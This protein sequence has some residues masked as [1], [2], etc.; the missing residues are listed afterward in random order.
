MGLPVPIYTIIALQFL[1]LLPVIAAVSTYFFHRTG[2]IWIGAFVNTLLITWLI[3][4]S[5]AIHYPF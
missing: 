2:R 1:A 5:Q 4:A 3:V